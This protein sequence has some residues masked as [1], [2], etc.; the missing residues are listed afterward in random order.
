MATAKEIR[1]RISSVQS[2]KK[3]TRTMELVSTAKA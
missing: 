1:R 3:I 2:T